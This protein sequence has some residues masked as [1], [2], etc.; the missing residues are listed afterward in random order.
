M[1][2]TI[3]ELTLADQNCSV[4]QFEMWRKSSHLSWSQTRKLTV[5]C[6]CHDC[7][8]KSFSDDDAAFDERN[9]ELRSFD[10]LFHY[11][12]ST[13]ESRETARFLKVSVSVGF[14]LSASTK[15]LSSLYNF[16]CPNFK[17]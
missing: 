14:F 5:Y 8:A 15:N 17:D 16:L 10:I 3:V 13:F 12:G 6:R 4:V 11:K 7:R 2:R 9:E 1:S